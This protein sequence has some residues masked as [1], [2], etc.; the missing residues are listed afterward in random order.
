M[1]RKR[2][3]SM[4]VIGIIN[5]V[6][7]PLGLAGSCCCGFAAFGLYAAVSAA[8]QEMKPEQKA[9]MQDLDDLWSIFAEHMP[10]I[11]AF[12]VAS[13]VSSLVMYL[14]Q[15]I[16]G[17]GL[18]LVRSWGRWLCALW[19]F[20]AIISTLAILAYWIAVVTPGA[21]SL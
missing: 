9:E 11:G 8:Y 15:T 18:V 4:L 13:L 17:I 16:S 19:A 7:G 2:P 12:I 14:I 21:T 20:L 1:T 6:L 10:G 3:V 5:L